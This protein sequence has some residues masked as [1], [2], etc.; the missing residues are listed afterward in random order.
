MVVFE[1]GNQLL[2][3][4]AFT[5]TCSN[6]LLNDGILHVC[7]H[8][9]AILRARLTMAWLVKEIAPP[10]GRVVP[11]QLVPVAVQAVRLM[12]GMR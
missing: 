12:A 5:A 8:L 7:T 6:K 4:F 10:E 3:F 2:C 11:I 9:L 1:H